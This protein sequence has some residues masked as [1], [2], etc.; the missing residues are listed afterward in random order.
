MPLTGESLD[1]WL[2][3]GRN[4]KAM[5]IAYQ[6]DN[7]IGFGNRFVDFGVPKSTTTD[8]NGRF[9]LRGFGVDRIVVVSAAGAKHRRQQIAVLN[10]EGTADQPPPDTGYFETQTFWNGFEAVLRPGFLRGA[11]ARSRL[12][13]PSLEF[14]SILHSIEKMKLPGSHVVEQRNEF[15]STDAEGRF[16]VLGFP[17]DSSAYRLLLE[18]A[19]ESPYLPAEVPSPTDDDRS[20]T[21][22]AKLD[23][24]VLVQGKVV[25][26]IDGKPVYD[27][28][29]TYAAFDDNPH[30]GKAKGYLVLSPLENIR[31]QV[32]DRRSPR[33]RR[34]S[35]HRRPV[36]PEPLGMGCCNGQSIAGPR[37]DEADSESKAGRA[38]KLPV[39]PAIIGADTHNKIVPLDW[40]LVRRRKRSR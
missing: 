29:L 11:A 16:E 24:G 38:A 1:P 14:S 26:D 8:A 40:S 5:L 27:T 10:R 7:H 22:D 37:R 9:E 15:Q 35:I 39:G 4:A 32:P 18:P 33:S 2:A 13:L 21:V 19:G 28:A 6:R 17:A 30:R 36:P 23:R 3:V 12:V 25:D 20:L 34:L 31:W